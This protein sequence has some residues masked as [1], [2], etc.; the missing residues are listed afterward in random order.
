[1][2]E[3]IQMIAKELAQ[4]MN[5]VVNLPFMEEDEEQIFFQLVVTKVFEISLGQLMKHLFRK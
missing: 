2:S 4:Q 3:C 5:K 1:M